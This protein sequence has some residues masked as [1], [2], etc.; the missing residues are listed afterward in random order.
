MSL[1]RYNKLSK[2]DVEEDDKPSSPISTTAGTA[3][4]SIIHK[5]LNSVLILVLVLGMIFQSVQLHK[6]DDKVSHDL[7]LLR[8]SLQEDIALQQ[9]SE[10]TSNAF[11]L[12][13]VRNNKRVAENSTIFNITLPHAAYAS[14][15]HGATGATTAEPTKP[16]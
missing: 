5:Y 12:V 1:F 13:K 10:N 15:H 4:T 11:V 16:N 7:N 14:W 8:H 3:R 6:S 2:H 9:L